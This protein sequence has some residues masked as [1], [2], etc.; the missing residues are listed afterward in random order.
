MNT[1]TKKARFLRMLAARDQEDIYR[2]FRRIS[3]E[4]KGYTEEDMNTPTPTQ[5]GL[6]SRFGRRSNA[7]RTSLATAAHN[8]GKGVTM[9]KL[10]D[11]WHGF[12]L[13][14]VNIEIFANAPSIVSVFYG[15]GGVD[16]E[17]LAEINTLV[18]ND[19]RLR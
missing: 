5:Q 11:I 12:A 18:V 6:I 4:I 14:G 2:S 8:R 13:D 9:I 7:L 17:L 3:M 1:N 19:N 15:H 16:S 10:S